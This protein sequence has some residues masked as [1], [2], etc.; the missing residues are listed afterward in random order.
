M[1]FQLGQIVATPGALRVLE[2]AGQ[3]PTEFL[4]R[5]ASGDWGDLDDEDKRENE[6][7]VRNGFRILS[8]YTTRAGVKIW[9]ITEADRSATTFLLPEEY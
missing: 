6:F 7:S 1:L 3:S 4:D 2:Q 5:H 8:A 9:V